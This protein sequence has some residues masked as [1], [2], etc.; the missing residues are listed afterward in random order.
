MA[1]YNM[2]VMH[3]TGLGTFKACDMANS[4]LKA[5]ALQGEPVMSMGKAYKLVE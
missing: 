3:Y 4:F 5:V 1:I 2:G